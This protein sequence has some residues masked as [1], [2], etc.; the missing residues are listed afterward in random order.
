MHRLAADFVNEFCF[1]RN[2][3][4]QVE[5]V[6]FVFA[7]RASSVAPEIATNE[8]DSPAKEWNEVINQIAVSTLPGLIDDDFRFCPRIGIVIDLVVIAFACRQVTVVAT[9]DVAT[10]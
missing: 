6:P 4:V 1:L 9:H 3:C 10:E 5:V 7:L 2:N 8:S